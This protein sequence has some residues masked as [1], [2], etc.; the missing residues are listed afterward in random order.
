MFEEIASYLINIVS[1]LFGAALLLRAWAQAVRLSPRNPFSQAVFHV[2][3]WLVLPL[4]KVLPGYAGIDWACL[5]GAWLTAVVAL[6]LSIALQG[7]S[8]LAVFPLGLLIALLTVLKWALNL[9][10]W[11]TV[12]MGVMSWLNPRNEAMWALQQLTAPCL[13]PI[14]RHM[15]ATGGIDF[16]PLVLIILVQVALMVLGRIGLGLY[17][18]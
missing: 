11:M 16:S 9:V 2:T 10:L 6:A 5:V 4:R 3:N 12:L 14:R 1:S 17:G 15:P 7:V 8:P 18:L 13:N